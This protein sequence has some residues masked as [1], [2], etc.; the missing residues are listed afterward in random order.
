MPS[1][2]PAQLTAE[3]SEDAVSETWDTAPANPG[4]GAAAV[5]FSRG[6][7]REKV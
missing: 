5:T 4:D 6:L 2:I 1:P 7:H 3:W